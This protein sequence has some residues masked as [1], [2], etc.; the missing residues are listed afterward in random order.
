MGVITDILP[1]QQVQTS[2]F[3]LHIS[4][5][6]QKGKKGKSEENDLPF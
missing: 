2:Q 3:E 1:V 5:L 4:Y 6:L